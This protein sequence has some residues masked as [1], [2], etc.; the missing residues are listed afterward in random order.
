MVTVE[1]DLGKGGFIYMVVL[2]VLIFIALIAT[3]LFIDTQAIMASPD[4]GPLEWAMWLIMCLSIPFV[5]YHSAPYQRILPRPDSDGHH[6][7]RCLAGGRRGRQLRLVV[8]LLTITPTCLI[9]KYGG[10]PSSSALP[11]S[12]FSMAP[13]WLPIFSFPWN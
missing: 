6:H 8:R 5:L 12:Q 11:G 9:P 2:T 10:F 4:P 1:K 13:I 7:F 3:A